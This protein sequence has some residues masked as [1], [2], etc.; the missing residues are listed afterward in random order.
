MIVPTVARTV[1]YGSMI[2]LPPL[3]PLP[4]FE[5]ARYPSRFLKNVSQQRVDRNQ[6]SQKVAMAGATHG[7]VCWYVLVAG[8]TRRLRANVSPAP[9]S[10]RRCRHDFVVAQRMCWVAKERG[11]MSLPWHGRSPAS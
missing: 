5:N 4:P 6:A 11:E 3:P 2:L 8:A 1:T 9:D 10:H 7:A